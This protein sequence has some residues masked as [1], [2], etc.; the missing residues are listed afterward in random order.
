MKQKAWRA[1]AIIYI[2]GRQ[3]RLKDMQQLS[4]HHQIETP[5]KE[6]VHV[7]LAAALGS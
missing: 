3:I 6:T 4:T 1:K 2:Y 7:H 5:Q